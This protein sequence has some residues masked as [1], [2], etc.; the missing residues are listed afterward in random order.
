MNTQSPFNYANETPIPMVGFGTYLIPD[1]DA[2]Q[3][4]YQALQTGYRHIDTAEGYRNETGVGLGLADGMKKLGLLR[5]DLFLTTKLWPGNQNW[6]ETPKTYQG[7]K[8]ALQASLDR[9][10][11]EYVD[12]YLIHAP[13]SPDQFIEQWRA[14]TDLKLQGKTRAIGVSNF[15]QA[16]IE[17]LVEAGLP[18]PEVN[19]IELHPWSQKTELVSYLRAKG[20]VPMA[21]SSLVPLSTWRTAPEQDS[22]KTEAMQRDSEDQDSPFK[23]LA[24]KY[25]V[26]EAQLLL[27]WGVQQGYPVIPKSTNPERMK[28]NL[29]LFS[30]EINDADM[31]ELSSL[32]RGDGVA[33]AIGSPFELA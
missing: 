30:F 28:Q 26:S 9:L 22:A 15:T 16:H 27:R 17:R 23:R 31:Q 24:D 29:A 19:Q 13:F 1:D 18:L 12:L 25:G 5:S 3:W 10:A 11:L 20:I 21:Y 8:D 2:R 6:G 33:W 32:D 7:T 4:V 14:L